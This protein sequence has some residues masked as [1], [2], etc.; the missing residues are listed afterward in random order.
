MKKTILAAGIVRDI[1]FSSHFVA[2]GYLDSLCSK[3]YDFKILDRYDR[4]DGTVILRILT[5]Y[6]DCDLI[7]L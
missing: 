6:N 7:E 3:Y 4:S 1:E 5:Q 2:E